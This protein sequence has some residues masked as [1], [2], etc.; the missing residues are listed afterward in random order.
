MKKGR[1][2]FKLSLLCEMDQ[3]SPLQRVLFTESSAIGCRV[4]EV[5][6]SELKRDF[7]TFDFKGESLRMKRVYLEGELLKYKV[8]N[9]DLLALTSR[10]GQ[11]LNQTSREVT[12]YLE[13]NSL[14]KRL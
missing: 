11:S 14:W 5:F 10:L 2:G 12:A 13:E 4:Y 7:V 6:K 1:L 8:E 9:D 3:A